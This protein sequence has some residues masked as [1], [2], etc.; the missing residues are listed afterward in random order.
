MSTTFEV[1]FLQR[2]ICWRGSRVSRWA[3]SYWAERGGERV[4]IEGEYW[5]PCTS[6]KR[7]SSRSINR[8]AQKQYYRAGAGIWIDTLWQVCN[9]HCFL[10][11]LASSCPFL[12]GEVDMHGRLKTYSR[13]CV[14]VCL[15][16][17]Q[18]K[19]EHYGIDRQ[20]VCHSKI[21]F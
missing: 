6:S 1:S 2:A 8:A 5:W 9:I 14:C 3:R 12:K 21:T 18:I 11:H 16:M 19:Y 17:Q 20:T 7:I 15:R 10:P 4:G 13:E